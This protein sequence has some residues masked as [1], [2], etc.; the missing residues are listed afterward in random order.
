[1]HSNKSRKQKAEVNSWAR[2]GDGRAGG[3]QGDA[4]G[5][6]HAG[7]RQVSPSVTSSELLRGH[8]K[9]F[10]STSCKGHGKKGAQAIWLMATVLLREEEA[11]L[12]LLQVQ[13]VLV[14]LQSSP[15]GEP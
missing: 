14:K 9:T 13:M 6:G 4:A 3:Q 8:G 1:M 12:L 2:G 5:R 11:Q 7:D 10:P 15:R